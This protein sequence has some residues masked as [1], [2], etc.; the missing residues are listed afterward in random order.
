[1]LTRVMHCPSPPLL[2][3]ADRIL[4]YLNHHRDIGLTYDADVADPVAY[5]DSDF[6]TARSTS[7]WLVKWHSCAITWGSKQQATISLSSCEAEIQA[8]SR[9]AQE[10]IY[11][12][13]LLT[14]LGFEPDGP[15]DLYEDNQAARATAYNNAHHDRMKHV[16]RRHLYIRECIER[17][18]IVVPYV[19]TADNLADFFTK[20]LKPA[21]FFAMRDKIM[22]ITA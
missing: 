20:A 11:V 1:M 9:A 15:T 12:R 8:C 22:N 10:V 21:V 18:E 4:L 19:A 16:E 17:G 6:S 13:A 14:E 5:A 7:G 2:I 3:A